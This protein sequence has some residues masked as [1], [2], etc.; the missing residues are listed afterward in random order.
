M[1]GL[2]EMGRDRITELQS[3]IRVLDRMLSRMRNTLADRGRDVE[4]DARSGYDEVLGYLR[5]GAERFGE[6]ADQL[7]RRAAT[8]DLSVDNYAKQ[9]GLPPVVLLGVAVGIGAVIAATLFRTPAQKTGP[10]RKRQQASKG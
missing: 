4:Q 7:R 2:P 8:V 10:S 1:F 5:S 3:N 9:L 6:G